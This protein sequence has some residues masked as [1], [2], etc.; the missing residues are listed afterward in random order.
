[1][2]YLKKRYVMVLILLAGVATLY[3]NRAAVADILFVILLALLITV[4]LM[5]LCAALERKGLS[6]SLSAFCT[7]CLVF[8]VLILFTVVM[9]PYLISQSVSLLQSCLPVLSSLTEA[10]S[11]NGTFMNDFLEKQNGI[12][13]VSGQLLKKLLTSL[14]DAGVS[15]VSLTGKFFFSLVIA[16]YFLKERG[17]LFCH[18][19]LFIP[20]R[21][22]N[23]ALCALRGCANAIL[24]YLSGVIKTS[25]FVAAAIYP[26]LLL[27][28]IPHALLLSVLMGV[29][30]I[31]PYIG[32][33][34]ACIPIVLSSLS[35]GVFPTLASI[36]VVFLVQQ[37][38]GNLISPYFTASSTSIHPLTALLS[39][40]IFGSLMGIRGIIFAIPIV[41]IARSIFWSVLQARNQMNA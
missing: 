14:A 18:L 17:V 32:P 6:S 9:L 30:E 20:T 35:L 5:P 21:H 24:S 16:Y 23:A 1:M 39:V 36:V 40:F 25:F 19:L 31:L 38:E 37:L 7:L 12:V 34:I 28:R 27:L 29:L 22:R 26:G 33:I 4:L 8:S 13:N 3:Q 41:V 10:I 2:P 11:K 15:T